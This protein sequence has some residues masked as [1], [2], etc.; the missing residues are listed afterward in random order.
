MIVLIVIATLGIIFALVKHR[1]MRNPATS[2]GSPAL[3]NP[4]S[5]R[6]TE[7]GEGDLDAD[8]SGTLGNQSTAETGTDNVDAKDFTIEED[9]EDEEINGTKPI[10]EIV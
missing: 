1:K 6:K 4:T 8:G 2:L 7:V 5:R 3:E 9:D 10:A